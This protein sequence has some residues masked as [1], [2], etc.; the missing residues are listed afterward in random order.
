M[1]KWTVQFI[2]CCSFATSLVF[3]RMKALQQQRHKKTEKKYQVVYEQNNTM[4]IIVKKEKN[5]D[6]IEFSV[7]HSSGKI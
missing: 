4:I 1:Q 3:T 5:K 7:K 2:L 6:L